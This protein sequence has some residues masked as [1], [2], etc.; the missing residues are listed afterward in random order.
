MSEVMTVSDA[1]GNAGSLPTI[2]WQG[3][4]YH[5]AHATPKA[6]QRVE[7]EVARA[8]FMNTQ[9][10]KGVL[11]P[12]KFAEFEGRT[13]TAIR[14]KQHGFGQSLYIASLDGA[15][16]VLFPLFGCLGEKQPGVTM[17]D[18]RGMYRDCR[19][20]VRFALVQCGP[21]FF[22]VGAAML[23][24]TPEEQAT[25]VVALTKWQ[26]QRLAASA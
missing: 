17:E 6:V 24:A 5:V 18:V 13:E 21:D 22:A 4:T 10:M 12:D 20:E 14:L 23:P 7:Q 2:T 16:G 26:T 9:D 25:M 15:D 11:P 3:K 8:A 1:V 19:A